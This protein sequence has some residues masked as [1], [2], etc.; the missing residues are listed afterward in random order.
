MK[1]SPPEKLTAYQLVN[2]FPVLYGTF[3]GSAPQLQQFSTCPYP[4]PDQFSS[5]PLSQLLKIYFILSSHIRLDLP[6]ALFRSGFPTKILRAPF[7]YPTSSTCSAH[8]IFV[9]LITLILFSEKY[10]SLTCSVNVYIQ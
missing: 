10:K 7:P 4:A 8:P 5:G 6:T 2:K 9:Y 3:K 1:H